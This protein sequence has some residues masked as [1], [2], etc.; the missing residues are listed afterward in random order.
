LVLS[1]AGLAVVSVLINTLPYPDGSTWRAVTTAPALW[2]TI[3]AVQTAAIGGGALVSAA[4]ARQ[5]EERRQALEQLAAA[6]AENEGLQRQ[7]LNQAREAGV[8]DER[9]RLSQEIH[10]TLAQ[11]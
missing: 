7:L 11:G 8:F 2:L 10:G 6:Q 5:S 1:F 3:V 9:Q 4:V